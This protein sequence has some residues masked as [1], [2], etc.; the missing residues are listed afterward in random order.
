ML[1]ADNLSPHEKR[2]RR[3]NIA[4]AVSDLVVSLLYDD[5]KGD[6][7][8][9]RGAIQDAIVAGEVT[10]AEIADLFRRELLIE[11]AHGAFYR[12]EVA[13]IARG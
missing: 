8:L 5:R 9:P 10:V 3:A 2:S 11:V 4:A 1:D 13:A 7:D 12:R 6:E